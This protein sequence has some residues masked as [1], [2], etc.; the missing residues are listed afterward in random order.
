LSQYTT[1]RHSLNIKNFLTHV[2]EKI[3]I[4]EIRR[5]LKT[6]KDGK[7]PKTYCNI[8]C[9]LKRYIRDF[10]QSSLMKSFEFP[11]ITQE[12]TIVHSKTELRAFFHALPI[13]GERRRNPQ[14][15]YH[16]LFL[17]LSS[18][19]L[20]LNEVLTLHREDID[21]QQRMLIPRH[22]HETN[23]TKKSWVSFYSPE[24]DQYLRWLKNSKT[25]PPLFPHYANIKK[26]FAKATL[27]TGIKI[28][29]QPLRKWFCSE[30]GRLNVPD[31]YINALCGR[32]AKTVLERYYSDFSPERLR[33]IYEKAGLRVLE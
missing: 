2:D 26:A 21:F 8:L 32:T 28:S 7:A 1:Y 24:C 19:G 10:K 13:F 9:S 4:D 14:P 23:T 16:A 5:Y 18:S 27:T 3:T 30:M 29:A 11:N 22:S 20:R 31:R 12:P 33:E 6:I 25:E 17:L 15:K